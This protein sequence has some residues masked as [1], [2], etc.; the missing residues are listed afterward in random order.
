MM[1]QAN[2]DRL[3]FYPK[4][5]ACRCATLPQ[6]IEVSGDVQRHCVKGG[7]EPA[8]VLTIELTPLQFTILR[9]L[10]IPESAYD[11]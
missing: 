6:L 11:G 5:R 8:V 7:T 4:G 9:L 10:G 1:A 2:V 3:R